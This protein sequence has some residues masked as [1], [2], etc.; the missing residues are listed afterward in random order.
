MLPSSFFLSSNSS[1]PFCTYP[2]VILPL[3]VI[4]S[5]SKV[6]ILSLNPL[7]KSFLPIS[8]FSTI[9][10]F[11]KTNSTTF[12][13]FL[14]YLTMFLEK[15]ITP[16]SLGNSLFILETFIPSIGKKEALP[17]FFSLNISIHF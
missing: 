2:P 16:F 3:A 13:I 7:F 6:T 10:E 17:N 8:R 15:S 4:I 1:F 11:P 12:S 14:L 9:T 5:P